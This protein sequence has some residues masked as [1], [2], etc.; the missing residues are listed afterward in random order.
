MLKNL[1]FQAPMNLSLL[2]SGVIFTHFYSRVED[3]L[4]LRLKVW[5]MK[6][7]TKL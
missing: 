5:M 2:K 3:A 6:L 1:L 4:T 7:E